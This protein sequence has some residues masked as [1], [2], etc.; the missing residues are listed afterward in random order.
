MVSSLDLLCQGHL[1]ADAAD[2]FSAGK[3]VP[4]L[5]AGDLGLAVGDDH[6]G[7]VDPFVYADFKEE[8]HFVDDYRIGFASGDPT[9][10]SLLLAGDAGMDDAF[11]LSAFL[12]IVEDD[13]SEGLAVERAVLVEDCLPKLFDDRSPGRFTWLDDLSRQ[14]VGID[15]RCAALL[16]HL[17]DGAFAGGDAACEPDQN[18]GAEDTMGLLKKSSAWTSP[19]IDIR[20]GA[21]V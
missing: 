19:R 1:A 20:K 4:S 11:E 16:E 10:E 3:S 5:E 18:H 2:R 14:Q 8:R 6:D 15:H 13:A 17:G 12:R 9:H 7:F 21:P